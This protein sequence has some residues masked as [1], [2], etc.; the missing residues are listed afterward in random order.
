M[1]LRENSQNINFD[2]IKIYHRKMTS[3]SSILSD[4]IND[5]QAQAI[6]QIPRT[7]SVPICNPLFSTTF[8]IADYS[9]VLNQLDKTIPATSMPNFAE[10]KFLTK[11][12]DELDYSTNSVPLLFDETN[13]FNKK[14]LQTNNFKRDIE[15]Y[16]E[17]P[18]QSFTLSASTSSVAF[19]NSAQ[20]NCATILS[21]PIKVKKMLQKSNES[22]N[23]DST[24][25]T[26][27]SLFKNQIPSFLQ[28]SP[29]QS[30]RLLNISKQCNDTLNK[31]KKN[32]TNKNNKQQ[33]VI[34]KETTE[35]EIDDYPQKYSKKFLQKTDK[36]NNK[37]LLRKPCCSN[38][39]I[40]SLSP[41]ILND[42]SSSISYSTILEQT[43]SP[44]LTDIKTLHNDDLP[45]ISDANQNLN[46]QNTNLTTKFVNKKK[47]AIKREPGITDL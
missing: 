7:T 17:S 26:Q 46:T 28:C 9:S 41:E 43:I 33:K 27:S 4:S 36:F 34:F 22:V 18:I 15:I 23:D 14:K 10:T 30:N 45:T 5:S 13:I 3:P 2:D 31:N 32:L 6:V 37:K 47:F 44:I 42:P 20:T 11:L 16:S 21:T 1:A 19:N 12:I 25:S 38:D 35:S 8:S 40:F 39:K 24:T 29:S